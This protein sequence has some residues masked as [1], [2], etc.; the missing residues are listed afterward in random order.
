[1]H[2]PITYYKYDLNAKTVRHEKEDLEK[3]ASSKI[4]IIII[5]ITTKHVL[6]SVNYSL[7]RI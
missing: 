5:I 1:M 4:L 7:L 3:N 2:T 6:V